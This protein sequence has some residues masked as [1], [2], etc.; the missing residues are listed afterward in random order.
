MCGRPNLQRSLLVIVDLKGRVSWDHPLRRIKEVVDAALERLSPAFGCMYV[1][2]GRALCN[3]VVWATDG[4]GLLSDEHFS[5]DGT[6]I[7]VAPSLGASG[8]RMNRHRPLRTT[9]RA[10]CRWISGGAPQNETH[11]SATDSRGAPTAQGR[12]EGC[13]RMRAAKGPRARQT[14]ET[15]IPPPLSL[16]MSSQI[17]SS[18]AC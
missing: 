16:P 13:L 11:A 10:I 1:R 18:A 8:L 7:E 5:V 17:H 2:V 14:T 9:I 12:W 4:E 3:E 15:P 6:L